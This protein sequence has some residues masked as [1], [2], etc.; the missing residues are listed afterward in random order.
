MKK[1]GHYLGPH[2]DRHLLYNDWT[3]RD[4]LLVSKDQFTADLRDNYREMARFGID[5]R[6]AP[7]FLP[8]YEW[9]NDSI[10]AWTHELGFQLIN[11]TPGTLS[12]ADYTGEKDRRFRSS[13]TIY[14]SILTHEQTAGLNGYILLL[15]I[16]A[17]PGRHD[18]FHKRLPGLIQYLKSRDYRFVSVEELVR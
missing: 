3:R 9:Y 5:K 13:E 16:G 10:A 11:H 18:K 14:Q 17:G 12:H 2:S 15:H 1:E 4:S 7:Y 8:P 6:Q